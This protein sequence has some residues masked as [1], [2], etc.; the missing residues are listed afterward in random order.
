MRLA[1]AEDL[2]QLNDIL[3][4]A[5]V[6]P[7]LWEA[8][9]MPIELVEKDLEVL[10]VYITDDG[11]GCFLGETLGNG[12]YI[13][14]SAFIRESWGL[15]AAIAHIEVINR[16]MTET[17]CTHLYGICRQTNR[18]AMR[19]MAGV[20]MMLEGTTDIHASFSLDWRTW[21]KTFKLPL[22]TGAR[23]LSELGIESHPDEQGIVGGIILCG[24]NFQL[25]KA[26]A[27]ALLE[28]KLTAGLVRYPS[29]M[30][31]ADSQFGI[32]FEHVDDI[33]LVG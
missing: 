32:K 19:N 16:M 8:H 25:K 17:D 20:G 33:L 5:E 22:I 6:R 1:T 2:P 4:R 31:N 23:E 18:R 7:H 15:P 13:G 26:Y 29:I 12:R 11:T 14:A 30:V 9:N 28:S 21:A 10:R 27:E 24:L 3:N